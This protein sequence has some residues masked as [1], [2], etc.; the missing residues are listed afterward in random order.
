LSPVYELGP[1]ELG[2]IDELSPVDELSPIDEL[3]PVELGPVMCL[4][5]LEGASPIFKLFQIETASEI[6]V[7]SSRFKIGS[8]KSLKAK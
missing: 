3:S 4:K 2:P 8:G 7:D 5:L 1:V 6:E